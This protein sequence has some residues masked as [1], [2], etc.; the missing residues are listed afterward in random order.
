MEWSSLAEMAACAEEQG[1]SL[2]R[3][4]FLG[5]VQDTEGQERSVYERMSKSWQVMKE[6]VQ[7]GLNNPSKS[8]GGM[9]GGEGHKLA[10]YLKKGRSLSG[11]VLDAVSRALAVA[12]LN[13]AMG[14]IVAA[15][16]AGSCGI[17]PGVL[18]MLQEKLNLSD[19]AVIYALFAASGIGLI[20]AQRASLSG[21]Q[22]GC[23][24][25]CGS[26]AAMAAA[27]VVELAGG[28]PFQV[29]DAVA[30][31]MKN[32]LGLVCDP[33]AG[34]VEVPCAKRNALGAANAL[35]AADMAL[36]GIV[37]V[38]PADEVIGAMGE[39]GRTMPEA[40]RETAQGGLARTPTGLKLAKKFLSLE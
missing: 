5:E 18:T 11:D 38:I 20:I 26:A 9:I 25:E 31:S 22:G 40:L 35:V 39:I 2:G 15:P 6:A 12:E 14:K 1:I 7:E 34:L 19:E 13:A 33:V 16:T 10:A 23:Q 32:N 4:V 28:T 36:A 24:A 37:S 29:L 8:R 27:A 3:L 21:A 17:I 30:I